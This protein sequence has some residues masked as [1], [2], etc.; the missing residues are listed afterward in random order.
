MG[1]GVAGYDFTS[2]VGG[3]ADT[4]IDARVGRNRHMVDGRV[5]RQ[6]AADVIGALSAL[7]R[8][9]LRQQDSVRRESLCLLRDA[10][11]RAARRLSD[12]GIARIG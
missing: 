2:G 1:V 8:A 3:M 9:L 6:R 7:R 11:E 10:S 5:H 12:V 4:Q